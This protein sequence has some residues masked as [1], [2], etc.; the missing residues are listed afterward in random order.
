VGPKILSYYEDYFELPYPLP[1]QDM[2]AIPDFSAG[3]MENWGLITYRETALLYQPGVSSTSNKYRVASVRQFG[4]SIL[5]FLYNSPF[6]GDRS[7][8]RSS[9]VRKPRDDE[10]VDRSVV[11]R[12]VCNVHFYPRCQ[13]YPSR[14]ERSYGRSRR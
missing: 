1:K 6:L 11:E 8:T 7:R 14:L 10:M 12:R 2:L 9:M 3:A 4:L 5:I 13:S